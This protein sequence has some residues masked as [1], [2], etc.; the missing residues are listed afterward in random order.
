[1]RVD[2]LGGTQKT[3]DLVLVSPITAERYG[4]QVKAQADLG[5]LEEYERRVEGMEGFS[6]FYFAVHSPSADLESAETTGRVQLLRPAEVAELSVRY[7]LVD[8]I[9]DKAG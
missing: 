2:E 5:A 3:F 9:I 1:M 8:W 7:G 4:V 6:R